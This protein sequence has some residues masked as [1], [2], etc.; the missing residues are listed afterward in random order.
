MSFPF[1]RFRATTGHVGI[2]FEDGSV[3]M[4]Q[5]R[6]HQGSLDVTGSAIV[7]MP[8]SVDDLSEAIRSAFVTGGFIGGRCVVAPPQ[9]DVWTQVV[10]MPVMPDA[11]LGEAASWEA[12]D[13]LGV[14]RE[15]LQ[16]DWMRLSETSER[17]EVLIMAVDQEK[18]NSMLEAVL[19]AGLRPIAVEPDFTSLARLFCRRRRREVD[20]ART[21]AVLHVGYGQ[22]MMMV[23]KGQS[24]VFCKQISTGGRCLDAAVADQLDLTETAASELRQAR[25]ADENSLDPATHGA[26]ADSSRVVLAELARESMRC[27]R[28]YAVAV[29]GE[30]P[31]N[32]LMGGS[33]A[34]EPGLGDLMHGACRLPV[35]LD[36]EGASIASL[37]AGL[38]HST[39][40]HGSPA[41]AWAVAAGLS[42][43]GIE[44][45]SAAGR[46]AA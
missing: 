19:G 14:P 36:D 8:H 21:R 29:R 22:S 28:H 23:L 34:M 38:A 26:V 42:V 32:L 24:I 40:G 16:C 25:L 43:R 6:E 13:R 27:L 33:D 1:I 30:R 10:H 3:R 5:V 37:Q 45:R 44:P 4:L 11:E 2:A 15:R 46:R 35:H 9:S 20:A 39:A 31:E 12:A 17:A 18:M 7:E 41:S